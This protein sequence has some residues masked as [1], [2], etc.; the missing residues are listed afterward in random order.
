M[1][2]DRCI[3]S[4]LDWRHTSGPHYDSRVV[5]NCQGGWY[6]PSYD[7]SG[8]E[9]NGL[10][11][12]NQSDIYWNEPSSAWSSADVDD[13]RMAF[14]YEMDDDFVGGEFEIYQSERFAGGGSGAL[15]PSPPRTCTDQLSRVL[16][17]YQSG[18]YAGCKNYPANSSS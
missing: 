14:G 5:R 17:R 10:A 13:V 6:V 3:D 4:V 2:T 1:S 11:D 8:D 12:L 15:Y 16:T 7:W 18:H 9:A